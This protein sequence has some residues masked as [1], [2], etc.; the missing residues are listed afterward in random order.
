MS[1]Q[2]GVL[3]GS[4]RTQSDVPQGSS[5]TATGQQTQAPHH[6]RWFGDP[7]GDPFERALML[8]RMHYLSKPVKERSYRKSAELY[9][10]GVNKCNLRDAVVNNKL[11]KSSPKTHKGW[12]HLPYQSGRLH[13]IGLIVCKF[14]QADSTFATV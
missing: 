1:H 12:Q 9:G 8:A 10:N 3:S 2:P 13:L 4:R 7:F 6:G 11:C 14:A 5:G